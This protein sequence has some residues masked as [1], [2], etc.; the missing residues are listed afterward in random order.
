MYL[1]HFQ[2]RWLLIGCSFFQCPMT[3]TM[4]GSLFKAPDLQILPSHFAPRLQSLWPRGVAALLRGRVFLWTDQW[5]RRVDSADGEVCCQTA[6][7]QKPWI[8]KR[9]RRR[10]WEWSFFQVVLGRKSTMMGNS[11]KRWE[12][13]AER[14]RAFAENLGRHGLLVP[15]GCTWTIDLGKV[16]KLHVAPSV[17]MMVSKFKY[18]E[19]VR[20]PM[21]YP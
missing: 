5:S 18:P 17:E 7:C 12:T 6:T 2:T 9:V 16:S 15:G 8:P 13:E 19:M 3:G 20:T 4:W 10:G 11:M 14:Q 1:Y 21:T